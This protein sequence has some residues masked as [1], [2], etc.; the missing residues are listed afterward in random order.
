ML[1]A[2]RIL[3]DQQRFEVLDGAGDGQ[4]AP[5]QTGFADAGDAFVGVDDDEEKITKSAPDGI[6][7]DIGNAHG[8]ASFPVD[9]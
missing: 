8:M 2:E 9:Q 7:G 1:D 6:A 3:A 4:L 5:G